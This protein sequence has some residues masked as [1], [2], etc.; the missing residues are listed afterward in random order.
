MQQL[1]I[2]PIHQIQISD[3]GIATDLARQATTGVSMFCI[4]NRIAFGALR[5]DRTNQEIL[6]KHL[7]GQVPL[8]RIFTTQASWLLLGHS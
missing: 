1:G 2:A 4:G 8:P 7:C 6:K 5:H 3:Q